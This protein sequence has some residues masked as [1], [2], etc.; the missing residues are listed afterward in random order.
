MKR[1]VDYPR[2][3]DSAKLA[4]LPSDELRAEY[5]WLLGIAGPNGSFE[6]SERRIWAAAYAPTRDNT[7]ADVSRYL[8]A[9]LAAQLLLRW[10]QDGKTWG[11]FVGSEMPGRLPRDSWKKKFAKSRQ[12]EPAPPPELLQLKCTSTGDVE[13]AFVTDGACTERANG[14]PL[15]ESLSLSEIESEGE[16]NPSAQ[17]AREPDK[18]LLSVVPNNQFSKAKLTLLAAEIYFEYPRH[19][20]KQDAVKSIAKAIGAVA[21]RDFKD[22]QDAAKEWLKARVVKYGN[23]PQGKRVDRSLIPHPATWFNA[24]RYDDNE[25]EWNYVGVERGKAKSRAFGA[26]ASEPPCSGF[27]E[28][29][30]RPEPAWLEGRR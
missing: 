21:L 25:S 23:S 14:V 27:G 11:Y 4:G 3:Y 26:G 20:A 15:L 29:L 6:W 5:A 30:S 28:V 24:G 17:P 10:E 1:V 2:I 9:F 13:R 12:L 22:D 18:G 19:V 8:H 16:E 7:P